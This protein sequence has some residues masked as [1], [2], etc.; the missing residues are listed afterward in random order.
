MTR[1]QA[2][3]DQTKGDPM[4]KKTIQLAT[5][6]ATAV[7]GVITDVGMASAGSTASASPAAVNV[8]LAKLKTND[9]SVLAQAIS[10]ATSEAGVAGP[11]ST[12]DSVAP[13]P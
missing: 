11:T 1:Q 4:E 7:I 13:R 5:V 12:F 6:A 10:R 2:C 8:D 9:G 3:C